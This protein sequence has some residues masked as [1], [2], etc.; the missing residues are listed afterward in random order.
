ME[1]SLIYE[2]KKSYMELTA[3]RQQENKKKYMKAAVWR[4]WT[5]SQ[6]AGGGALR[7]FSF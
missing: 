3:G 6:S 1:K 2:E 5:E 4:S 7:G